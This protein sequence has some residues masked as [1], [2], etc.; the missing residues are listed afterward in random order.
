MISLPS[1]GYKLSVVYDRLDHTKSVER[2][3]ERINSVLRPENY[4]ENGEKLGFY[5]SPSND[6][7]N[8]VT[9]TSQSSV[10]NKIKSEPE[11]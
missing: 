7:S 11:R 5:L 9:I 2:I 3:K 6:S 10:K 4:M 1:Q 8:S